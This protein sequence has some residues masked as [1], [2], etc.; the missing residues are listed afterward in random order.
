MRHP[1]S[2]DLSSL[3]VSEE[4]VEPVSSSDE[5]PNNGFSFFVRIDGDRK[6]NVAREPRLTSRAN[7]YS[8]NESVR[9]AQ[10]IECPDY[11]P[12]SIKKAAL[13]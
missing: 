8:S 5:R 2:D 9:N 6:V 13:V 4:L 7:G 3:G 12:E 1:S 10:V 11:R